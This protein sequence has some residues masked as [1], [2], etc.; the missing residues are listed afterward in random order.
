MKIKTGK[1]L[2][3]RKCNITGEGMNKGFC[4]EG[5][6]MYIK[7]EES[8][9]WHIKEQTTYASLNEAYNDN[10]YYWTEWEELDEDVNYTINGK[11][12]F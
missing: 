8:L 6:R 11:E 1:E 2:Y 7:Y 4:V 3:P 10:Y 5:G 9:E 12:I